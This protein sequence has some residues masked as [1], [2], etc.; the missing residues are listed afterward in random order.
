MKTLTRYI[1]C[2][3]LGGCVSGGVIG[4]IASMYH[5]IWEL[6]TA[7]F[8]WMVITTLAGTML[9]WYLSK[10]VEAAHKYVNLRRRVIGS[11]IGFIAFAFLLTP[12]WP[13]LKL[14][15]T[16]DIIPPYIDAVIIFLLYG[17]F[18]PSLLGM[19]VGVVIA[20]ALSPINFKIVRKYYLHIGAG[21]LCGS[22][23]MS[24]P[25]LF[26]T[27]SLGNFSFVFVGILGGMLGAQV[28][29][30]KYQQLSHIRALA[31]EKSTVNC[32]HSRSQI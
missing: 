23:L 16:T 28:A 5:V 10:P 4:V 24:P 15:S 27:L 31:S 20:V 8:S 21:A 3:V 17:L 30:Y 18:N 12:L 1:Y 32:P 25:I 9:G 22:L 19:L 2:G 13:P 26:T 7:S 6:L 29:G 14:D 11:S